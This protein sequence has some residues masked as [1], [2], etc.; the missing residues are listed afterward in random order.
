[1]CVCGRGFLCGYGHIFGEIALTGEAGRNRGL[2]AG[3]ASSTEKKEN[4]YPRGNN[5]T[6]QSQRKMA[7]GSQQADFIMFYH[8]WTTHS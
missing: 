3:P 2:L 7:T 8:A 5:K 6:W 4:Q 1:M